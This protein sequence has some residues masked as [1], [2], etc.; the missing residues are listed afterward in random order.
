MVV[1][2]Y[3]VIQ[4]MHSFPRRPA[5]YF[6]EKPLPKYLDP[7]TVLIY[8]PHPVYDAERPLICLLQYI[9]YVFFGVGYLAG[10]TSMT[11]T[12]SPLLTDNSSSLQ[13]M[14]TSLFHPAKIIRAKTDSLTSFGLISCAKINGLPHEIKTIF[15]VT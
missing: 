1:S 14:R 6:Y 4:E 11:V 5:K 8:R 10:L 9:L 7:K 3:Y 15:F 12:V 2:L 13:H